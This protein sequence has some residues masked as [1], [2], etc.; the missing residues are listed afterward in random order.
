MI[1]IVNVRAFEKGLHFKD[2]ELV[3]ILDKGRH[4]FWNPFTRELVETVSTRGVFLTHE[5]LDIIIQ[6][7]LLDENKFQTLELA[8]NERALVWENRRFKAVLKPGSHV[9]FTEFSAVQV[10]VVNTDA[11]RFQ[12]QELNTIL[13]SVSG[14]LALDEFTVEDEHEGLFF[15]NGEFV[16]RLKPGT[17]AFWKEAGKTKLYTKSL[18]TQMADISGQEILTADK[19]SIRLNA[20]VSYQLTD[21]LLAVTRVRD[22]DQALYREAQLALRAVV[23]TKSLE[24]LLSNRIELVEELQHILARKAA[25]FGVGIAGFG[26]RDIILPGEMKDLL[27]KV[28]EA[29][30]AAEA[31]L[32]SRREEVAAMR[33]QANV[34]K[35]LEDNPTLMRLK[36]LEVLEKIIENNNMQI[37]LGESGLADKIT[38]LI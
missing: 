11:I 24:S 6:S 36:E 26:I 17:Y 1:C 29:R 27:N 23:G 7:G 32:I 38:K 28:I 16:E 2:G 12:H 34:A 22:V 18:R 5:K 8:D 35:M 19:V 20:L 31:N 37:V 13:R 3:R 10:E 21:T 25:E 30:K 15:R 33:S 4:Y 9:L 14:K